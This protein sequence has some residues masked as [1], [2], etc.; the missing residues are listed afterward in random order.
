LPDQHFGQTDLYEAPCR[1]D[2]NWQQS[3]VQSNKFETHLTRGSRIRLPGKSAIADFMH[4]HVVH[5]ITL[6]DT[7]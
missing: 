4:G 7:P 3:Q 2:E 1:A 5:E 6:D